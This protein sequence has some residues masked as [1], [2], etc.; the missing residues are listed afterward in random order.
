MHK[1][2]ISVRDLV[3]F[4]LMEG[5]LDTETFSGSS[6]MLEGTRMHQRLQKKRPDEYQKE[7]SLSHIITSPELELLLRGRI[8]GVFIQ[9]K[10]IE[11]I[12]STTRPLADLQA[13]QPKAHWGQACVYAC[14]Y[15]L[16]YNWQG[17]TVRLTYGNL[18]TNETCQFDRPMSLEELQQFFDGLIAEYQA[19]AL[20]LAHWNATRTTSLEKLDFPFAAYRAGQ[21]QMAVAVYKAIADG[22]HLMAEAPTGIGKTMAT[23]FPALKSMP[24]FDTSRIFYFTARTTGKQ[25]AE[26][27]LGVLRNCGMKA[28]V[29]T[30][31]AKEKICLNPGAACTGEECPFARGFFDRL[32]DAVMDCFDSETWDRATIVQYAQKHQVCPFEFSLTMALWCDVLIGDYNYGFDPRVRLKRFFADPDQAA[33][34]NNIFLVDEAHNL[35]DRSREMFSAEINK[36]TI[37]DIR[38]PLKKSNTKLYKLFSAVNSELLEMRKAADERG[39]DYRSNELPPTLVQQLHSLLKE[40]DIWLARNIHTPWRN[41]LRDCYFEILR[42]LRTSE[43]FG[44]HYCTL[45]LRRGN[46]ITVQLYCLHPAPELAEVLSCTRSCTVFSATLSPRHFYAHCFGFG[47]DALH[48]SLPSPFP[49]QN[50]LTMVAGTLSTRYK[51]RSTTAPAVASMI[52]QFI[53]ARQG[54]YLLFFPSYAYLRQ[55]IELV[56]Q[57]PGVTVQIQQPGMSEE[58]RQEFLDAFEQQNE[59]SIVGCAVMGGAFGEGIDLVGSSLEGAVIVGVGLPGISFQRDCIR[60]FYDNQKAGFDFAYRFPGF[61]RVLQAVGRVIRSEEDRGAVLLIDDRLSSY[62]YRQLMPRWWRT[63]RISHTTQLSPILQDF[64]HSS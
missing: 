27:S 2:A 1:L 35:V 61:T 28:K 53:T 10:I 29:L 43:R 25:L 34:D 63:S 31:T 55:I 50:L 37:L 23:L 58:E 9:Q 20:R 30:L 44:E 16:Q 18:D 32:R 15:C 45:Y 56:P 12:K 26:Q 46:D 48:I 17:C 24:L 8:D 39:D 64:W 6:R 36:Q 40:C 54:N 33:K 42:F 60:D 59:Q 41:D 13:G 47:Q 49:P 5:D 19:W 11:E 3:E 7:V 52:H 38:R 14:I 57:M 51:D 4:L 22:T 62:R 21:R